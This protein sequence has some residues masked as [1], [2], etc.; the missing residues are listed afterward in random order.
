MIDRPSLKRIAALV[1]L[2][3]S[4]AAAASGPAYATTGFAS[5][6]L[7]PDKF[8]ENNAGTGF[9]TQSGFFAVG[10]TNS[11]CRPSLAV[12]REWR[13]SNDRYHNI[14][15]VGL[16]TGYWKPVTPIAYF[17]V[18]LEIDRLVIAY[19]V[20]PKVK[21]SPTVIWIQLRWSM[22]D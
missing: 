14:A 3:A 5:R 21:E 4:S 9:I 11:L 1:L 18:G 10:Y 8:C 12:G 22:R 13:L 19:G 15:G 6:H 16:A 20:T 7:S 17:G 2:T